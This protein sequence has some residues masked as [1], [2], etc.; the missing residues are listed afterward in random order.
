MKIYSIYAIVN[1][2]NAYVMYYVIIVCGN[3]L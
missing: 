1:T 2:K 3:K